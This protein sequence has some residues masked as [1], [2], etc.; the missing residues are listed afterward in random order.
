MGFIA[1]DTIQISGAT[2]VSVQITGITA[3]STTLTDNDSRLVTEKA[4]K[5]YVDNNAGSGSLSGLTDTNITTQVQGQI[6]T[7]DFSS[8]K[9]INE[10]TITG[11][12]TIIG[13]LYVSGTTVTIDVANLNVGDNIIL[14]NSGETGSGVTLINAGMEVDRGSSTNYQFVFNETLSAFKVGEIG[15]LQAVATRQDGPTDTGIPYWNDGSSRFDTSTYIVFDGSDLFITNMSGETQI[16]A[17]YYNTSTGKLTYGSASAGSVTEVTSST[18]GQL[19]VANG[20]STPAITIVTGAVVNAGTALATGDQIYDFVIGLGYTTNTGT[21]TSVSAGDGLDFTTITATGPVTLGTPS[22]ITSGS[23]DDV[24]TTSH[25]HSYTAS[26]FV[27]GTDGILVVGNK[28]K[29]DN[30]YVTN[31]TLPS[32]YSYT[33]ITSNQDI[34]S[35]PSGQTLGMVY[36]TNNG[37]VEASVNLGTTSNGNEISPYTPVII[38][39]GE[40]ISVTV[41]VRLSSTIDTTMYINASDWT[42]VN[43]DLEWAH[44]SYQNASIGGGTGSVTEVTSSTTDQLTVANPTTAPALSIVT[45]AVVNDGTSLAT[46]DQIYD[47]VTGLGYGTV[48][49]GGTGLSTVAADSILT[50]NGT[51]AL[52]AETGLTYDGSTLTVTGSLKVSNLALSAT[53]YGVYYDP[54]TSGFTY[55]VGGSGSGGFLGTITKTDAEPSNLSNNQ[56]LAPSPQGDGTYE[57]TFDNFIGSGATPIIVNLAEETVYLRYNESGNYWS[58]EYYNKPLASGT[59]WI[60]NGN[61]EAKEVAVVDEWRNTETLDDIGQKYDQQTQTLMKISAVKTSYIQNYVYVQ[62]IDLTAVANTKLLD[63]ESGKKLLVKSIKLIMLSTE[64]PVSFT[65][66]VGTNSSTYNNIVNAQ[67]IQDVIVDEYYNLT[68]LNL[69]AGSDGMIIDISSLNVYFRVSAT[70]ATTLTAH[71]LL[72]GFIY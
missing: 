21:V 34:G 3:G 13:D 68:L 11:N 51:S 14:V 60:G 17:V 28:F 4:I 37:T 10:D 27:S 70:N 62:D 48:T 31:Q 69:P 65:V 44:I 52:T 33:G 36:I 18:T 59:T 43:I 53:T 72:E 39:S 9:W 67:N 12:L 55:E 16:N 66:N 41:N 54:T 49:G 26:T 32:L 63:N 42:N 1:I 8:S 29:L 30:T 50:G 15:S 24:T 23:T 20:T 38:S 58:K 7:Y 61:H 45:G 5:Y 2:E 47:F 25:T 40:T 64:N 22:P 46:G 71:L 6:L 57:Y 56:W 35:L 19:T